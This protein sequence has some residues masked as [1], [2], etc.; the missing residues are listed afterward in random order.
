MNKKAGEA[1]AGCS[2]R[3]GNFR[4]V[5]RKNQITTSPM[6][7]Q[8]LPEIFHAHSTALNVPTGTARSPRRL[9]VWLPRYFF[10]ANKKIQRNSFF[11][12]LGIISPF[13]GY[14][15]HFNF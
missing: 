14:R 8:S 10:L 13:S 9:P 4:F 15:Q 11:G 12:V 3:L 2:F 5:M 7:V 1:D 6:D